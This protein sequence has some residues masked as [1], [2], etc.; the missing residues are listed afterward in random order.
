MLLGSALLIPFF[1]RP[2]TGQEWLLMALIGGISIVGHSTLVFA[3]E[4]ANASFLAPYSYVQL[5]WATIFGYFVFASLPTAGSPQERSSSWG[6]GSTQP[7]ANACGRARHGKP[8]DR[9]RIRLAPIGFCVPGQKKTGWGTWIRTK[10]NGV[11]VRCSTV[12][13]SPAGGPL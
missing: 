9:R 10:T 12:K 6:A 7:I 8:R 1:W 13:L 5:I 11:R 2:M 4:R 3:Y